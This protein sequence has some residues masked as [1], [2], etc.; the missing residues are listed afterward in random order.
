[1]TPDV[2]QTLYD[3]AQGVRRFIG[4]STIT[5]RPTDWFSHHLTVGVDETGDDSRA[6]ERFT[7][8]PAIVALIGAVAAGGSIGQTLR[9]NTIVTT[10]YTANAKA[11]L[12]SRLTATTGIGGQFY[13][14]EL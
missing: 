5:H 11:H 7:A 12:S 6:I 1:Y 10:E 4:S 8:D 14:T 2:P 3:N 9:H 13:R